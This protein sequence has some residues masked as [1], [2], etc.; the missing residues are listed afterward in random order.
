[1][2]REIVEWLKAK[3][4]ACD[5]HTHLD[6]MSDSIPSRL[7]DVQGDTPRLVT[8]SG[9]PACST[10]RNTCYAA[11]SYC[12]GPPD[13][14][15]FQLKTTTSSLA[16]RLAGIS[17]EEIRQVPA[18][19]DAICVARALAIPYLW[20]DSLCILQDD[21]SDWEHECSNM[22]KVYGN[23]KVTFIASSSRSCLDSFLRRSGHTVI[24]PFHSTIDSN[25]Q[26][27]FRLRYEYVTSHKKNEWSI[28]PLYFDV[29][30]RTLSRRGW[31]I[32]ERLLSTR[33]I[34]FGSTNVHFLCPE[35]HQSWGQ[36]EIQGGYDIS[37]ADF[38]AII[39][40]LSECWI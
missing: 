3:I 12:W 31:A 16:R 40:E 36:R 2:E 18:I 30:A 28:S 27:M 20:I 39:E 15:K 29:F 37:I 1:M 23:A 26:G 19:E 32:Q 17:S 14:A 8:R 34:I 24:V 13:D 38:E 6:H 9:L 7:I 4:E 5:T 22:D 33:K 10:A 35:H 11:L 21:N 25:V